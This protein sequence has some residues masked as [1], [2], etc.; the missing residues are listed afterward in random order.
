MFFALFGLMTDVSMIFS[1]E[2]RVVRVIQDANRNLSVGRL[3]SAADTEEYVLAALS[4]LSPNAQASTTI[5]SGVAT[6]TVT[7]PASDFEILGMFSALN[8]LTLSVT[9][10]Q[11]IEF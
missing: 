11:Y 1:G 2:T 4:Q 9:S 10:Q 3:T 8:N 7:M 5:T 6:T